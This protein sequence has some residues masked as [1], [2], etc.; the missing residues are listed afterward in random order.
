[1][2]PDEQF[3]TAFT[4]MTRGWAVINSFRQIGFAGIPYATKIVAAEHA[5]VLDDLA[6]SGKLGDIIVGVAGS[7][8]LRS[9]A[10]WLREK[11]TEQSVK[12]A[13]CSIDAASL[14]FAHSILDDGLSSFL[15]ITSEVAP[16]FWERRLDEKKVSLARLRDQSLEKLLAS[17]VAKEVRE[18]RRNASVIEKCDLLHAVCKPKEPPAH[19]EYKFDQG[20]LSQIDKLRHDL[21]HGDL[22][23]E[24]I[25]GAEKSL[26][27]LQQTWMYFFIMLHQN[28][29]LRIDTEVFSRAKP[30]A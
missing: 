21:V 11:L 29:G 13:A 25:L 28:F 6:A 18:V 16:S 9:T 22:L 20:V 24:E 19:K 7:E 12:N 23:G 5:S 3:T 15:Q 2:A 4:R 17:F 10:T 30:P 27:Y 8:D 1:M 26:E 14:V